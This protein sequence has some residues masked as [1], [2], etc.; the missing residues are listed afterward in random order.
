MSRAASFFLERLI[1]TPRCGFWLITPTSSF[2]CTPSS[3]IYL[4]PLPAVPT[5]SIF[6]LHGPYH[7][8]QVRLAL[9]PGAWGDSTDAGGGP[10][11][12]C[13]FSKPISPTHASR[14]TR[15]QL[16]GFTARV[17]SFDCAWTVVT[18]DPQL[19][20]AAEGVEVRAAEG[21]EQHRAAVREV[22]ALHS[23]AGSL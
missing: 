21:V 11:P 13:L 20:A 5:T 18:P 7:I 12:M 2:G 15:Q 6:S 22:G 16:V 17:D 23:R 19:R 9:H 1:G 3:T 14:Y 4:Q 8:H 10:R